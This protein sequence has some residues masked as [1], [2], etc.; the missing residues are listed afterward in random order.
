MRQGSSEKRD[1][2][3]ALYEKNVT[4]DRDRLVR[5]MDEGIL[6]RVKGDYKK[7]NEVFFEAAKIISMNGYLSL[8]DEAVSVI[9]DETLTTYQGEDFEKVLVHLYLA[10]NFMALRDFDAAL[11]EHRRVNE[12]L[13]QMIS[14]GRRPYELNEFAR[15]LGGSL[16]ENDRDFNNAR[17]SYAKVQEALKKNGI[18]FEPLV[19][20]LIR[21]ER[22]IGELASFRER[23]KLDERRV[24]QGLTSLEQKQGALIV[25]L[26]SGRAPVK[27]STRETH[28]V[29][30]SG[31]GLTSF[32]LPMSVFEKQPS[33][34]QSLEVVVGGQRATTQTLHDIESVAI[35]H[36]K[37]RMGRKLAKA[38]ARAATRV[39]VGATIGAA[40]KNS[41]FGIIAAALLL[42]AQ[43]ADTRSWSLLPA[44][45]QVAKVFLKAGNYTATL[46]HLDRSGQ[47]VT[48][49]SHDIEIRPS[50]ASYLQTRVFD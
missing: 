48:E 49:E 31:G 30:R 44:K 23:E 39:A 4:A 22:V 20:D 25:L 5:L 46:R 41:D 36:L 45:L 37:D 2:A 14:E 19:L 26:E 13:Y 8:S 16:F 3:L 33:R 1:E 42:A 38:M 18:L 21:M 43:D 32:V 11:V 50:R 15:Y 27:K 10:L 47:V 34:I 35:Q 7:S 12:I 28:Q 6:H 40:T 29:K 24:K 17:V 9:G